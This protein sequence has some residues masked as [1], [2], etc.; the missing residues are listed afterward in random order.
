MKSFYLFLIIPFLCFSCAKTVEKPRISIE[1]T[2]GGSDMESIDCK[3]NPPDDLVQRFFEISKPISAVEEHQNYGWSPC[4]VEGLVERENLK[5]R[6]KL[7]PTG[8]SALYTNDQKYL[9]EGCLDCAPGLKLY[10]K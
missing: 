1:I 7:R 2:G 10:N 8:V 5:Y 3:F 9:L 6:F 4:Y